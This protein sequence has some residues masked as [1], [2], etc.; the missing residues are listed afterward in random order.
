MKK[1]LKILIGQVAFLLILLI[2]LEV[3]LKLFFPYQLATIGHSHSENYLK[4]GWGFN[5]N[6]EIQTRDPDTNETFLDY[7]NNHGWRDKNRTYDNP[8][9]K[10]RILS[11]GDSLAFSA[12]TPAEKTYTRILEDKLVSQGYNVEVINIS[13]GGWGTDQ[14]I[15]ALVNDGIKYSPHMVILET[16]LNDLTDNMYYKASSAVKRKSKPF[17]YQL[18]G[19]QLERKVNVRFNNPD[20][21][22]NKEKLKALTE[23]SEIL[24]RISGYITARKAVKS[25]KNKHFYQAHYKNLERLD[26]FFD[27]NN[28]DKGFI[29]M[30]KKDYQNR[31]LEKSDISQLI[32]ENQLEEFYDSILKI[33]EH[34]MFYQFL[35]DKRSY[36]GEAFD[37]DIQSEEW[38]LL[39]ALL[40]KAKQLAK[41]HQFDLLLF[42]EQDEGGYQRSRYWL[43]LSKN[44]TLEQY[45]KPARAVESF[46]KSNGIEFIEM[47][48][49]VSRAKYDPHPNSEGNAAIANNI[50]NYLMSHHADKL[51]QYK[52]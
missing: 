27:E 26:V 50:Y 29:D 5:P 28:L 19:T 45:L 8:E 40:L 48:E 32:A 17:Y 22:T 4:Y 31:P 33:L 24:K 36:T 35:W 47:K 20:F 18:N 13:Y 51:N 15:E 42:S 2:L 14:E 52:Y 3:F 25:Q 37:I 21:L 23:K 41:K 34:V 38:Q 10:F 11:L 44:V 43:W 6:D 9:N 12:I 49:L 46:A 16:A 30:L 39:C 1:T 7:A